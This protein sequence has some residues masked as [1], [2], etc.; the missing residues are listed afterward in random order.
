MQ[1]IIKNGRIEKKRKNMKYDKVG[2][3]HE[4]VG[5]VVRRGIACC[6]GSTD[7]APVTGS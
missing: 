3:H 4:V 6:W 2:T 7:S 5:V 1:I